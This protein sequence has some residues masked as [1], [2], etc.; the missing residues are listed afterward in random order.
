MVC[1]VL[2]QLTFVFPTMHAIGI[3]SYIV[4]KAKA[5]QEQKTVNTKKKGKAKAKAT[6]GKGEQE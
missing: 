1:T 6:K 2:Q 5:R 4:G 3:L